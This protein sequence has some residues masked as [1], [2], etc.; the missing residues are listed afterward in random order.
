MYRVHLQFCDV[1][2]M[3]FKKAEQQIFNKYERS[4]QSPVMTRNFVPFLL[5]IRRWCVDRE[6]SF[7]L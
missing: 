1:K 5:D 7:A 6:V 3:R 4:I 2:C